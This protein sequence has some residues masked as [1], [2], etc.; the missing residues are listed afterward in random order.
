MQKITELI[1]KLDWDSIFFG[2]AM[3]RIVPQRLNAEEI[4]AILHWCRDNNIAGLYFLC[5]AADQT[6]IRLAEQHKFHFTDIRVELQKRFSP[7]D[8]QSTP[9]KPPSEKVG[10][11]R[12]ERRPCTPPNIRPAEEAD[13][14]IIAAIAANAHQ[15]SRFFYDPMIPNEK[16]G[17]IYA[18]W[19][20]NDFAKENS[21]VLVAEQK[22]QPI[23]YVSCHVDADKTG[24]IGLI[25]V[26]ETHR[27][28]GVGQSLL[29]HC[30]AWCYQHGCQQVNVVTQGRNIPALRLYQRHGFLSTNTSLWY[31]YWTKENP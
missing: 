26:A 8:Q 18:N 3:A 22:T 14:P 17:Q 4:S 11:N 27:G 21:A 15:Q 16:A 6:S 25:G 13:M 20:A 7:P 9:P 29:S 28:H 1:K 31:H 5:D 12:L 24:H 19:I 30:L 10:H 2:C 23:G